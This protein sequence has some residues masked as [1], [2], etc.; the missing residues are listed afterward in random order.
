MEKTWRKFSRGSPSNSLLGGLNK[1]N[2]L[3]LKGCHKAETF[4]LALAWPV[5]RPCTPFWSRSS[6]S[7]QLWLQACLT[8]IDL[9]GNHWSWSLC[10]DLIVILAQFPQLDFGPTLSLQNCLM[11]WPLDWTNYPHG[12]VCLTW[13]T[14]GLVPCRWSH[15]F[16][17]SPFPEGTA[18]PL[19]HSDTELQQLK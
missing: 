2:A 14:V 12:I 16:F 8:T 15:C 5:L 3:L 4:T 10:P 7:S 11:F 19:L 6:P 9:S 18:E 1:G 17:W 13:G